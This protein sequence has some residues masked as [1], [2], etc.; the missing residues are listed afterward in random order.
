MKWVVDAS[1]VAKVLLREPDAPIAARVL[2]EE[3]GAPDLLLPETT[4]V[5]WRACRRGLISR[6][7]ALAATT[8]LVQLEIELIP[9]VMLTTVALSLAMTLDHP[10]Y[11]CFYLALA[12]QEG[13]PF[14]TADE[15]FLRKVKAANA[16][17]EILLAA[18]VAAR[19]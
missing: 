1:V 8:L 18:E 13:A 14:V 7:Q 5:L 9:S 3:I 19:L 4:N 15:S 10:A 6:D 11:D 16:P 12:L 17:V 2:S